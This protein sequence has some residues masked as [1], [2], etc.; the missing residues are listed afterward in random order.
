MK[1]DSHD[2]LMICREEFVGSLPPSQLQALLCTPRFVSAE[3]V[4]ASIFFVAGV[5]RIF[6]GKCLWYTTSMSHVCA[7]GCF[8]PVRT[9]HSLLCHG[10]CCLRFPFADAL[11]EQLQL[12]ESQPDGLIWLSGFLRLC[13]GFSCLPLDSKRIRVMMETPP[14]NGSMLSAHVHPPVLKVNPL[15]SHSVQATLPHKYA[16]SLCRSPKRVPPGCSSASLF[17]MQFP[18]WTCSLCTPCSPVSLSWCTSKT[19]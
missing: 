2:L 15:H 1:H 5:P 18:P 7:H 16:P 9:P 8:C 17:R 3:T 19:M 4:F 10:G 11:Q 14:P 13:T 12:W 6:Q